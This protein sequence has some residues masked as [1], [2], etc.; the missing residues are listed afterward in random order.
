MC[1][2]TPKTTRPASRTVV[3][4]VQHQGHPGGRQRGIASLQATL[5]R[6]G[7]SQ[8]GVNFPAQQQAPIG[9]SKLT[10]NFLEAR[11]VGKSLQ[12]QGNLAAALKAYRSAIQQANKR[13]ENV[14]TSLQHAYADTLFDIGC[15]LATQHHTIPSTEAL[16]ACLDV[17]RRILP[18][19]DVSIAIVLYEI[20]LQSD[21]GCALELLLEAH[22]IL[23]TASDD[24]R[25]NGALAQVWYAIGSAQ[26][27][28]GHLEAA[29]SAFREALA[30]QHNQ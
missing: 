12:E 21:P 4:Q 5:E 7:H 17:R 30:L 11:A 8:V 29:T 24:T 15:I 22:A 18:P 28:M 16:Y 1:A 9:G 2:I 14:P 3:H 27:A 13:L 10:V 20:S 23:N 19:T 26:Q 25:Y 6:D